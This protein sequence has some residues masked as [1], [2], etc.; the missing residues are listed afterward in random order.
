MERS[1]GTHYFGCKR[2]LADYIKT[3]RER[4]GLSRAFVNA[5]SGDCIDFTCNTISERDAV[6]INRKDIF[7]SYDIYSAFK[8]FPSE[9]EIEINP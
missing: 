8:T 5:H 4:I 3:L 6:S 1:L 2:A 7:S 9:V